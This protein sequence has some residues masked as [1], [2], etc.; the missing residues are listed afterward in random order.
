[1]IELNRGADMKNAEFILF[2]CMETLIDLYKLPNLRDYAA[3]GYEGAGVEE[4]WEDFE[5]YFQY[6]LLAKADMAEKL[7]EHQDY[8]MRDRFLHIIHM[9]IPDMDPVKSQDTADKIYRNYWRNYKALSYVREDVKEVL[10][11]LSEKYRLGVVSNFMV[12]HGIEEMLEIHGLMKHLDFVVTSIGEGWRKPHSAIYEK[13]L[14][15]SGIPADKIIFV[16]D[17]YINDYVTPASLG[18]KPIYLDRYDRHPEIVDRVRDFYT[19]KELLL[20]DYK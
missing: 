11:K 3:W 8:E 19:L 4:L 15:K 12:M 14:A 7:Q 1:M 13:A 2:D 10:P 17:D 16:G 5:E 6:Y 9:S 18:M 20:N